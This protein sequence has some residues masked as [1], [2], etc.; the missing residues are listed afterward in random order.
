[1]NEERI[2]AKVFNMKVKGKRRRGR[3]RSRW[4]QQVHEIQHKT[5]YLHH[6]RMNSEVMNIFET[7]MCI[8]TSNKHVDVTDTLLG[9]TLDSAGIQRE[10]SRLVCFSCG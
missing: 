7:A 9:M 6:H 1:M 4:E 10:Q 8:I 2:P 3:P 5:C